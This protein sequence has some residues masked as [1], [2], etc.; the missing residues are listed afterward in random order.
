[1]ENISLVFAEIHKVREMLME[2]CLKGNRRTDWYKENRGK[3][4]LCNYLLRFID[5]IEGNDLEEY[6]EIE[7][8]PTVY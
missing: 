3:L 7:E 1:M 2:N 8:C 6:E 5:E 4:A